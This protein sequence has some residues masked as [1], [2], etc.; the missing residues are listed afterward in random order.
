MSTCN[1]RV[2]VKRG[3]VTFLYK[4]EGETN[5]KTGSVFTSDDTLDVQGFE[6]R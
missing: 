2:E 3:W 4:E 5:D 1:L 6:S